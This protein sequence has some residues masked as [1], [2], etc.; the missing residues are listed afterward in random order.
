M[1]VY[2]SLFAEEAIALLYKLINDFDS[3]CSNIFYFNFEKNA[4]ADFV[5]CIDCLVAI[6]AIRIRSIR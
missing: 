2:L 4:I 3:F 5:V 6:K 1:C